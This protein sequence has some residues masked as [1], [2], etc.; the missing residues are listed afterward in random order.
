MTQV[1]TSKMGLTSQM[2]S[3]H[4]ILRINFEAALDTSFPSLA[5]HAAFNW[6]ASI[7][8]DGNRTAY[9]KPSTYRD[10]FAL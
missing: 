2:G 3:L 6:W 8:G 1:A 4:S 5:P 9:Q 7:E 10:V